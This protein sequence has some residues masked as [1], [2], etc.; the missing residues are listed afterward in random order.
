MDRTTV[1][2]G[3]DV[4]NESLELQLLGLNGVDFV[5]LSVKVSI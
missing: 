1:L 2:I 5:S 4:A 3:A